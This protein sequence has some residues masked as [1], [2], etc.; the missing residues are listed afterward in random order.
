[1]DVRN[2]LYD[3][4]KPLGLSPFRAMKESI[5]D[6]SEA[7][8]DSREREGSRSLPPIFLQRLTNRSLQ[9]LPFPCKTVS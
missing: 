8:A 3:L 4:H 1:M 9:L 7:V 5:Q 2:V 6:E